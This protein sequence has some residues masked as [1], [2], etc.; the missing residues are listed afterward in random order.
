MLKKNKLK[1]KEEIA[2]LIN[3]FYLTRPSSYDSIDNI[4]DNLERDVTQAL[5]EIVSHLLDNIYDEQ[6]MSHKID[7]ILLDKD[8][9]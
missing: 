1:L 4:T 5:N 6:E 9:P 2:N 3:N 7:G 8:A